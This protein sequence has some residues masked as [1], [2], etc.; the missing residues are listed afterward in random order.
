MKIYV[1]TS[2]WVYKDWAKRFYPEDLKNQDKLAY[3]ARH[4]DTVEINSTFYRLPT[5]R[6]VRNWYE[7]VPEGFIFAIKLSRYLTHKIRLKPGDKFDAGI[8][9][10]FHRLKFLKEKIGV[11]LVQLPAH[12]RAKPER[13]LTCHIK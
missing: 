10:Y 7:S 8:D 12:I 13:L 2:G 6:A 3:F 9:L 4:F 5:G 1:G 11:V